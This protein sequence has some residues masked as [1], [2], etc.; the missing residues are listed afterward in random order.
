MMNAQPI[1]KPTPIGRPSSVVHGQRPESHR[2]ESKDVEEVTRHFGSSSLLE[3]SDV[4]LTTNGTGRRSSVAPSMSRGGFSNSGAPFVDQPMY[5]SWPNQPQFGGSSLPGSQAWGNH[6][7]PSLGGWDNPMSSVFNNINNSVHRAG[8][9]RSVNLRLALCRAH[10]NLM[11]RSSDGYIEMPLMFDQVQKLLPEEMLNEK[12]LLEMC[13]TEGTPNNGGGFFDI[14]T[15][16]NDNY[17]KYTPDEGGRR[18]LGA[19]GEI[20]SPVTGGGNAHF[21][22]RGGNFGPPGGF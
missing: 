6:I 13:E 7:Q 22:G 11:S 2:S 10:H 14:K 5:G 20:G 3:E 12:E 4:L 8:H 9:P 21:G 19:P 16:D 18:T 17:I 1:A 15:I